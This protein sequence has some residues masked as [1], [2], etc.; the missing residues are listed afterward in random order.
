[1]MCI[2]KKQIMI[3]WRGKRHYDCND[4]IDCYHER[5]AFFDDMVCDG[6]PP[7]EKID[8]FFPGGH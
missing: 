1:M 2:A 8:G 3:I 4:H 7:V 6:I 5:I